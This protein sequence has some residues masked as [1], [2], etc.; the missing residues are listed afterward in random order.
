[1]IRSYL[2]LLLT[3]FAVLLVACGKAKSPDVETAK[4][5]TKYGAL[6]GMKASHLQGLRDELARLESE[7]M[8]ASQLIDKGFTVPTAWGA[9]SGETVSR[10][11]PASLL[12]VFTHEL[13]KELLQQLDDLYPAGPFVFSS[14]ALQAAIQLKDR[15]DVQRRRIRRIVADLDHGF[16]IQLTQGLAADTSYTDVVTIGNRL[17]AIVAAELLH[18]DDPSAA[19]MIL[20]EMTVTIESLADEK[21]IVPRIVAVHRRGEALRVMEAIATHPRATVETH[22]Q[23]ARLIDDQLAGWPA[24]ASAWIGDRAIGMHTY[25]LVRDGYLLSILA[26]DERSRLKREVG[27]DRLAKQ[28]T[29]NL[30]QDELFYLHSMRQVI[31]GCDRPYHQRERLF[32]QINQRL[33]SLRDSLAYPL[34]ADLILWPDVQEG[35]RLQALDRARCE[36]WSI[37]LE[38]SVGAP[39]PRYNV[40]PLTG[41]RYIIDLRADKVIVDGIDPDGGS[42]P[43]VIPRRQAAPPN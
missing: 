21:H 18:G 27:F 3:L 10:E 33:E 2:R 30:D 14:D 6:P 25:E 31:A 28:V 4:G 22:R 20:R 12:A 9:A 16:D 11:A 42:S 7:R 39:R 26:A 29:D 32:R 5:L 34:V 40:N 24:D 17:D 8:T 36:A 1:M 37:A 23:L 19:I 15:Y 43:I 35:H 41:T 38:A 13:G